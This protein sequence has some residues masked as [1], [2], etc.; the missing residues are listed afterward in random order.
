MGEFYH[1]ERILQHRKHLVNLGEFYCI[2][3]SFLA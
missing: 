2:E 1:K 3:I